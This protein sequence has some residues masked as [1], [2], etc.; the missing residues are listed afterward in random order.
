VTGFIITIQTMT[1]FGGTNMKNIRFDKESTRS[2]VGLNF[3]LDS[4]STRR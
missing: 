2:R 1:L 3:F 4:G